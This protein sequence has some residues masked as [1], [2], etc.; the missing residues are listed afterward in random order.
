MSACVALDAAATPS[1]AFLG[2]ASVALQVTLITRD[3]DTPYSGMLPGHIAGHYTREVGP[4]NAEGEI[5]EVWGAEGRILMP[6]IAVVI[7]T[8]G[9]KGRR[10]APDE[11]SSR[12]RLL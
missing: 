6:C 4:S 11:R 2:A 8:G 7:F 10:A 1:R 3:V 9:G 12:I 5:G